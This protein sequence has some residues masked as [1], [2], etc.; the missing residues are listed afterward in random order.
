M[1]KTLIHIGV[2]LQDMNKKNHGKYPVIAVRYWFPVTVL[3]QSY[4]KSGTYGDLFQGFLGVKFA[5]LHEQ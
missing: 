1:I 2:H 4:C 3:R 5:T